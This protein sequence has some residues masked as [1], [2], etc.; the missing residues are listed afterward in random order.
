GPVPIAGDLI[1]QAKVLEDDWLSNGHQVHQ[2]RL[3]IAGE[4]D[5]YYQVLKFDTETY[6]L[7]EIEDYSRGKLRYRIRLDDRQVLSRSEL[8]EG[9][10]QEIPDGVEVRTW[11]SDYPL[12]HQS[13]DRVWIISVDPPPSV[14]LA[15]TFS[16]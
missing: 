15:D 11:D 4:D 5:R 8:P 6:D 16:A 1:I 7:L 13:M 14:Y 2:V 10:F 12:G 9:F 3:Q